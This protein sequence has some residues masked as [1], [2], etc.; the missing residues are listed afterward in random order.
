[1]TDAMKVLLMGAG[2]A[3]TT[4][5]IPGVKR[6]ELFELVG[7]VDPDLDAREK[8]SKASPGVPVFR[9][10]A[11]AGYF[12][13]EEDVVVFIATPDHF[14]AILS[15][16]MDKFRKFIV[17]KPF[18][19]RIN[20]IAMLR[21]LIQKTPLTVYSIDHYYQKFLPLEFVLGKLD[22][23]DPRATYIKIKGDHEFLE[24]PGSL[25]EIEGFS[26]TNIE[27]E[28][29]GIPYLDNHP[30]TEYDLELGGMI[31]DLGPHAIAPPL[32]AGLISVDSR[33]HEVSL[34]K[35]NSA[36]DSFE[37]IKSRKDI[38]MLV[39]AIMTTDGLAANFTFGKV[40]FR[41]ERSFA[42]RG[43]KGTFFA[44]LARGQDSI[45]M[46][47]DGKTTHFSLKEQ[48]NDL[49]LREAKDF[50]EKKLPEEFDGNVKTSLEAIQLEER[51]RGFY[52]DSRGIGINK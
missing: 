33:I 1:M 39:H 6:S 41:K 52:Y 25:G 18:V 14:P 3:G 36:R 40:P 26:Y 17:E 38:D 49:V 13:K 20:E 47:S 44:G 51:I 11:E 4:H 50:F 2:F 42:V 43:R 21:K 32:R 28:E 24:I 12:A 23:N 5:W 16:T 22:L 7:I 34:A 30:W 8:A 9:D 10:I 29:L 45:L 46:T 19:A 48:E 27:G 35:F 31:H 37:P 15:A